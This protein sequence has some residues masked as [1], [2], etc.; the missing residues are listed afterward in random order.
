MKLKDIEE[1]PIAF[2]ISGFVGWILVLI[3][4]SCGS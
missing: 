1:S 4:L 2:M 3:I